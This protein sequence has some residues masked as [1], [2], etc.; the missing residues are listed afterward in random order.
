ML[1]KVN[2]LHL[3]VLQCLN[4]LGDATDVVPM[5]KWRRIAEQPSREDE[6]KIDTLAGD[7][8]ENHDAT[9]GRFPPLI[10]QH[11][12]K[13]AGASVR[14]VIAANFHAQRVAHVPDRHWRDHA[15]VSEAA[16][17]HDFVHGHLHY[18]ALDGLS[19]TARIVTFL[20]NPIQRV[21]SLYFFF[22]RQVPAAFAPGDRN[23]FFAEQARS[24]SLYEFVIH[25]DPH[26]ASMVG[27]YQTRML[28]PLDVAA[29]HWVT[30]AFKNLQAYYFVGVADP[31]L[32][33]R[34][35]FE[36]CKLN[37]WLTQSRP[38]LVNQTVR[39]TS[40]DDGDRA[41]RAIAERNLND[42]ALYRMGRSN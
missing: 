9:A 14:A 8:S 33:D 19:Q 26:I 41:S 32:I 12:P 40:L 34:S 30:R 11:I 10:F 22:R 3:E 37:G 35:V 31:D 38:E 18:D 28:F 13:T 15:F 5:E 29:E 16:A 2:R 20:R 36:L 27:D 4:V 7:P 1:R 24:L 6:A 42:S 25:S 21:R 39:D 23:R 17:H